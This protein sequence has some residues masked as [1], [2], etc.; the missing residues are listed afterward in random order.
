MSELKTENIFDYTVTEALHHQVEKYF[1]IMESDP[2]A[3]K[4]ALIDVCVKDENGNQVKDI[5]LSKYFKVMKLVMKVNGFG[6]DEVD[7]SGNG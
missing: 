7:E 6:D 2:I 1:Q 5:P 3:F 4:K